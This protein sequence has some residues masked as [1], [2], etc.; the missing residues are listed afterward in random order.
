MPKLPPR[1]VIQKCHTARRDTYEDDAKQHDQGIG[2][3][4]E[5]IRLGA[6]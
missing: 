5:K 1:S 4:L 3:T 2:Q 6:E